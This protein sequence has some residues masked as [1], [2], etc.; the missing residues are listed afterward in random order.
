VPQTMNN[1]NIPPSGRRPGQRQQERLVRAARRSRRIRNIISSLVAVAI[2]IV[3][4][5]G[6]VFYSKYTASV[7][8][9]ANANATSTAN[10]V[11]AQANAT[12]TAQAAVASA[13]ASALNAQQAALIAQLQKEYPSG[14]ATPPAVSGTPVNLGGGLQ[15]IVVK[16][17]TGATVKSGDTV[18]VEYTG[19]IQG[20]NKKF[21][22]SYDNGAQPLTVTVGAGQVIPGWDKGLVGMKVGETRRLIIPPSL[23]YGSQA[24][25]DSNGNVIIPANSTLIFDVT[26]V[27]F[28]QPST[29]TASGS[30]SGS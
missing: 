26:V 28:G 6:I 12:S 14:P 7:T 10:A 17:G 30:A 4:I 13:T 11:A 16:Q 1:A 18:N 20:T 19:W 27:G 9:Q 29:S 2:L 21:D 24:Q 5:L 22:S 23:A 8:A 3:A 25:K 15:Y